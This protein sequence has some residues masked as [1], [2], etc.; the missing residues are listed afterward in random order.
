M[1]LI[2]SQAAGVL[3]L[4]IALPLLP[5]ATIAPAD[6]L[7]GAA[8]GCAGSTRCTVRDTWI[9]LTM[10]TATKSTTA[11][12]KFVNGPAAITATFFQTRWRQ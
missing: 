11:S 12:T 5:A 7:W 10:Y 9:E 8:A 3:L 2:V 4:A 6:L 1:N